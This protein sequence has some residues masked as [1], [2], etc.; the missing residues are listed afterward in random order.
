MLG[1]AASLHACELVCSRSLAR[2]LSSPRSCECSNPENAKSRV[3]S[4][5]TRNHHRVTLRSTRFHIA[6]DSNEVLAPRVYCLLR[7]FQHSRL[8]NK[9][10]KKTCTK[11]R[12]WNFRF[13]FIISI[14]WRARRKN[15]SHANRR[16]NCP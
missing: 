13:R 9:I 15:K 4:K 7:F 11:C 5:K 12:D 6:L 2:V 3:M 14:R 10:L 16:K 8:V 1:T